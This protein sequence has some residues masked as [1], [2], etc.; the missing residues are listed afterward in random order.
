MN[1]QKTKPFIQ[2]WLLLLGGTIGWYLY[3]SIHNRNI[4]FFTMG[5][6][7]SLVLVALIVISLIKPKKT[8]T[9]SL[10]T[11]PKLLL[12]IT[13][14]LTA[15]ISVLFFN[16]RYAL[17][18]YSASRMMV[19]VGIAGLGALFL[20]ASGSKQNVYL[21]FASILLVF[22][23]LHRVFAFVNEIQNGVFSLGWS[24]GS[25]YYNAS[26]FASRQ[27][28]GEKLP[29]PV[30]HPSRYL[31]QAIPFWFGIRSILVHRIWQVLLWV[32]MTLWSAVVLAK[33]VK[34]D[35]KLPLLWVTLFFFLFFFQGAVYY[36]MMVC[37][38]LVLYGYHKDK[39]WRTLIF[40]LL[41]SIWAGISRVN[42]IPLPA[43]LAV[44]MYLIEEAF[45]E[46]R[47]LKYL[48]FPVLWTA[49]G[50]VVSWLS[51]QAYI[52]LS[53]EP[54]SLF[55]SAF[56]SAL[57]WER[58]LP[59]KTFFVGILPGVFLLCLPL[60]VLIAQ[61]MCGQWRRVHFLRWLG[62]AGIL[63]AFFAGGIVVSV[64][65]GGGGDLH[66]LDA[67][68]FLFAVFAGFMLSGKLVFDKPSQKEPEKN[69]L[70]SDIAP[71]WKNA[72]FWLAVTVIVPVFFAFMRAGRW[73]L[74]VDDGQQTNLDALKTALQAES[75]K[76][77][78]V[79]FITERQLL[80]FGDLEGIK[81]VHPYEKVFLM[82]MAMGNHQSYLSSFYEKLQRH[83]FSAIVTD[84][85]STVLQDSSRP[86][87]EENNVWV[88]KVVIPMLEHYQLEQAFRDGAFNLL[89]PKP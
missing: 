48:Q 4:W 7:G 59:N 70:I 55:D 20:M 22:G 73:Q 63:F 46:K 80:T 16:F 6:V 62:I 64:K 33:R 37:V 10:K 12:W 82:E 83:E 2:Q 13:Y 58:L 72:H 68:I 56:S 17:F 28:Y 30:L 57:L 67:F 86:F 8:V 39:P 36:H 18:D 75:I 38:L 81:M 79:L 52:R 71:F 9:L 76:E 1:Y 5:I 3:Q 66:N 26:L 19:A 42:W 11:S 24:E 25:R 15:I 31:M 89:V 54:A 21:H 77:G 74:A 29:W 88:T 47:W 14:L 27:V 69:W 53:G 60:L 44:L 65:I 45:D 40:V 32:G 35:L 34:E 23:V 84:P 61:R 78:P 49:L 41:A 51:K 43:L 50:L 87:N 85:I